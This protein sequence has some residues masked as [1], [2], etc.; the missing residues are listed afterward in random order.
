MQPG[1]RPFPKELNQMLNIIRD[2]RSGALPMVEI[3]DFA[4]WYLHQAASGVAWIEI[5]L[6]VVG[7]A[8]AIK[9]TR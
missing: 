8:V 5:V 3:P 4:I 2:I 1:Q 7:T 9:L 6:T